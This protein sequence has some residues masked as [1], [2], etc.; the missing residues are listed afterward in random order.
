MSKCLNE[1]LTAFPAGLLLECITAFKQVVK[2]PDGK[3]AVACLHDCVATVHGK[4]LSERSAARLQAIKVA[5]GGY[6]WED[7]GG[8]YLDEFID[9]CLSVLIDVTLEAACCSNSETGCLAWKGMEFEFAGFRV[10][11]RVCS[12]RQ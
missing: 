12:G 10:T 1:E 3:L 8:L 11:V 5:A 6:R 2:S 4:E 9:V 7:R